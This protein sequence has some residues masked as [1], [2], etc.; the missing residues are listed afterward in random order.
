[1]QELLYKLLKIKTMW[2]EFTQYI[3]TNRPLVATMIKELTLLIF[4]VFKSYCF[5]CILKENDLHIILY[6][7]MKNRYNENLKLL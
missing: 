4:R 3:T 2:A 6:K 1:M 5:S 7:L